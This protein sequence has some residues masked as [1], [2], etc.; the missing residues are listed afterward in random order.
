MAERILPQVRP[1]RKSKQ[2]P[3]VVPTQEPR[4]PTLNEL[5]QT[6]TRARKQIAELENQLLWLNL[7]MKRAQAEADS[8]R[9]PGLQPLEKAT[10]LTLTPEETQQVAEYL[11]KVDGLVSAVWDAE[12]I[13][14]AV[15]E[16]ATHAADELPCGAAA[17]HGTV[18]V[19]QSYSPLQGAV[20]T[21]ELLI[22]RFV[23]SYNRLEF[24][25]W[26]LPATLR[27]AKEEVEEL[28]ASDCGA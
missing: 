22:Q 3:P 26:K 23:T 12:S 9:A 20:C 25:E 11:Y 4:K 13:L 5:D 17:R 8:S 14:R 27:E 2:Q 15:M 24:A 18:D 1:P 7:E 6:A 28:F 10:T 21:L 19:L 16:I